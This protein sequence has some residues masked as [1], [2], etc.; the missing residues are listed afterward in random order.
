M[1]HHLHFLHSDAVFASDRS[2]HANAM[3]QNLIARALYGIER[4]RCPCIEQNQRMQITV[5][6]MKYIADRKSVA[7]RH[8]MDEPQRRCNLR[9]RHDPILNIRSRTKPPHS[10]E[11]VLA[12]FPQ[13]LAFIRGP[14]HT[15]LTRAA[16]QA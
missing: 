13:E 1:T 8:L 12:P 7:F 9:S 6:R 15:K 16:S 4:S 5:A 3:L 14:C 2:A 11:R 10:A